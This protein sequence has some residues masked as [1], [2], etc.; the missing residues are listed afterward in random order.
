MRAVTITQVVGLEHAIKSERYELKY[1]AYSS[2]GIQVSLPA[3]IGAPVNRHSAFITE[4]NQRLSG[5]TLGS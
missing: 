3:L 5:A 2:S 4:L 1:Q